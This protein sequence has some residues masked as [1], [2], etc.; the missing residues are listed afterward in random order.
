MVQRPGYVYATRLPPRHTSTLLGGPK[1]TT[2]YRLIGVGGGQKLYSCFYIFGWRSGATNR[3]SQRKP[4]IFV[5]NRLEG[6]AL[7][8]FNAML[9]AAGAQ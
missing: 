1:G 5:N 2:L 7:Q 3:V 4:R 9:E 8:T 6:N